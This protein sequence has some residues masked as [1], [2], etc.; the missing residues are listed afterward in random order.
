M[1]TGR[2]FVFI[3]LPPFLCQIRFGDLASPRGGGGT[4]VTAADL[5]VFLISAVF[6]F[7]SGLV[8]CPIAQKTA[9]IGKTQRGGWDGGCRRVFDACFLR[10]LSP[11]AEKGSDAR[12]RVPTCHRP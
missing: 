5:C 8:R 3:P 4:V 11:I 2:L 10:T 6:C 1:G 12:Q 7:V 9:E